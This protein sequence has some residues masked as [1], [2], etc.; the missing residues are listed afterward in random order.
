MELKAANTSTTTT[1]C[2]RLS[3]KIMIPWMIYGL[4]LVDFSLSQINLWDT[5]LNGLLKSDDEPVKSEQTSSNPIDTI[6]FTD[7]TAIVPAE[8]RVPL[9]PNTTMIAVGSQIDYQ[10]SPLNTPVPVHS[11]S[12]RLV[13]G[14]RYL[15]DFVVCMN[16]EH[17]VQLY[18]LE[19]K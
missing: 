18:P 9:I 8:S 17:F 11:R 3:K 14:P 4:M 1:L 5:V 13:K 2:S 10:S 19:L 16:S 15:N 12:G 6:S 7:H